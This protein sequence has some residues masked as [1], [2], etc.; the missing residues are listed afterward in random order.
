VSALADVA[1]DVA[2]AWGLDLGPPFAGGHHSYV[3]PAGEDAVLKLRPSDDDES[4]QEAEAL[5]LWAGDG[6]VRLLREDRSRRAVLLERALPGKDL[7][8]RPDSEATGIAIEVAL[9]LWR[10]AA[11]PFRWIGD[12]V[13][14]WLTGVRPTD[15]GAELLPLAREL[16]AEL[17]VGKHTLVHGDLHHHNILESG[18]RFVAIDPKPM[19]GEPEYDVPSFLWN[20]LDREM[21]LER[22]E[23]RLDAFRAAGLDGD[24]LRAWAV[25]RGSYLAWSDAQVEVLRALTRSGA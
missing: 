21:T 20:P 2:D 12:H 13:P 16:Y 3:A 11:E 4:D 14:S 23:R 7:S 22:T 6:A 1:R 10:P 9:R 5:I 15:P 17:D 8:G 18:G 19:L 24:R 25:I